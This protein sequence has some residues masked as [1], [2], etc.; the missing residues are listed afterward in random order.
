MSEEQ[1]LQ[2]VPPM[3]RAHFEQIISKRNWPRE[4]ASGG[5]GAGGAGLGAVGG[6][7]GRRLF[8]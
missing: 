1:R 4:R 6:S 2:K 5:D 8:K 3:N 7:Q